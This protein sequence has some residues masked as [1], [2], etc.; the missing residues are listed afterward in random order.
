MLRRKMVCSAVPGW[1]MP[2]D[3]YI[4]TIKR[5]ILPEAALHSGF[6]CVIPEKQHLLRTR[7]T[8]PLQ[9]IH[10]R[11]AGPFAEYFIQVMLADKKLLR[12]FIERH[13]LLQ[14]GIQIIQNLCDRI[15]L[16]PHRHFFP[17]LPHQQNP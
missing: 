14:M 4:S 13:L 11:R 1:L 9:I 8:L 15:F 10:H 2:R 5:R 17:R 6:F 12:K 7:D 3:A 16:L